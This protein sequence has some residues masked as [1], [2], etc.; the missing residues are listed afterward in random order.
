MAGVLQ[1]PD[2]LQQPFVSLGHR[3]RLVPTYPICALVFLFQR[4]CADQR[5]QPRIFAHWTSFS[6]TL[7]LDL[8][9]L[10]G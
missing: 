4:Q 8:E 3:A 5:F 10:S 9:R 7:W 1:L 6:L 2:A